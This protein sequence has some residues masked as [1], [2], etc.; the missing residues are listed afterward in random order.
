MYAGKYMNT[1][2]F[3]ADGGVKH[4]PEGWDQWYGQVRLVPLVTRIKI[5]Y[6]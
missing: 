6:L 1:Y 2:G 4:V 5:D 3:P